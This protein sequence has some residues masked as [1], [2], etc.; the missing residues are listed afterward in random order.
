M[1]SVSL[2][3]DTTLVFRAQ[4]CNGVK[5]PRVKRPALPFSVFKTKARHDGST[6]TFS[7]FL[8]TSQTFQQ[9]PLPLPHKIKFSPHI[10]FL[11]L[12]YTCGSQQWPNSTTVV[13]LLLVAFQLF[14]PAI[15]L[16]SSKHAITGKRCVLFEYFY[17]WKQETRSDTCTY[18]G[19]LHVLTRA[20][21]TCTALNCNYSAIYFHNTR[22]ASVIWN[23]RV[24]LSTP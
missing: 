21:Y 4:G 16:N 9:T 8:S 13:T 2:G 23:T 11:C 20:T 24:S 18:I 3:A 10:M 12:N 15:P 17:T 22:K 19:R 7:I 6:V 1:Q 5:E 14:L